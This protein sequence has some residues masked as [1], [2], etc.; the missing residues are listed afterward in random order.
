MTSVTSSTI[1]TI[2]NP[3]SDPELINIDL[4]TTTIPDSTGV[5]DELMTSVNNHL[6]T[7]YEKDRITGEEFGKIYVEAMGQAM[8][9]A[10]S[11]LLAKETANQQNKLINEQIYST[12]LDN[13][14]KIEEVLSQQKQNLILDKEVLIKDE[15]ITQLQ[16]QIDLLQSQD[17]GVIKD[18]LIKDKELLIKDQQIE[19][20]IEQ[21]DLLQ[22]QD[23]GL[24]KDNLIK[25]KQLELYDEQI[26]AER[27]KTKDTLAGGGAISG[28][29]SIEKQIKQAQKVVYD[30]QAKS[31]ILDGKYKTA[32]L[33]S[34]AHI[35]ARTQDTDLASIDNFNNPNVDTVMTAL[36]TAS[37]L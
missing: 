24:I 17:L 37:G 29:I 15:Q 10:V 3:V 18:N 33:Y 19:Q 25:D 23:L 27:G 31:F 34:S 6:T 5:F 14:R 8:Q 30:E 20:L 13:S 7:Q 35:A 1:N 2:T 4:L 9:T 28:T 16:E 12:Q 21:V 26:D 11:F 32:Q 36:K 22:T